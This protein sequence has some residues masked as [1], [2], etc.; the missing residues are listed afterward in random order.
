[1]GFADRD[2]SLNCLA[3]NPA[4]NVNINIKAT[5][6]RSVRS[7]VSTTVDVNQTGVLGALCSM[8]GLSSLPH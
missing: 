5:R 3:H 4:F 8:T 2:A 6:F 1:M 7:N